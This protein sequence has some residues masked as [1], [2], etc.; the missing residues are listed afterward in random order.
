MVNSVTVSPTSFVMQRLVFFLIN[1][2]CLCDLSMLFQSCCTRCHS[3]VSVTISSERLCSIIQISVHFCQHAQW[4]RWFG[5]TSWHPGLCW[6]PSWELSGFYGPK[7]NPLSRSQKVR[8]FTFSGSLRHDFISCCLWV[9]TLELTEGE[10]Y[11][12]NTGSPKKADRFYEVNF[13][14]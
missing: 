10:P 12:M 2:L 8:H 13:V 5:K 6:I 14:I 4:F 7:W 11:L 1:T 9:V 3:S